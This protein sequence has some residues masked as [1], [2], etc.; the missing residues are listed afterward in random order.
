M[1]ES[2][3]AAPSG[4]VGATALL[5]AEPAL[6]NPDVGDQSAKHTTASASRSNCLIIDLGK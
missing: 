4:W 2:N 6:N 1:Q 5:V 3:I